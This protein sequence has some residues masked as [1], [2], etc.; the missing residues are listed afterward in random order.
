VPRRRTALA[1]LVTALA[2]A[3]TAPAAAG[4]APVAL[5]VA[6]GD[7]TVRDTVK[8]RFR[9]PFTI[10]R[11][12]RFW[13]VVLTSACATRS[14]V[15]P[16]PSGA[17][18]NVRGH[19]R[20]GSRITVRLRPSQVPAASLPYAYGTDPWPAGTRAEK[21]CAGDAWVRLELSR[22]EADPEIDDPTRIVL[23]GPVGA[24]FAIERPLWFREVR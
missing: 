7:P 20:R 2:L 5:K 8:V 14:P 21:W 24:P 4:Y 9:A 19:R 3:G 1:T 18:R 13:R 15:E 10:R 12:E 17:Y 11:R 23:A 16:R 22:G 6:P